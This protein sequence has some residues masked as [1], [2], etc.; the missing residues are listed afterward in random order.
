VVWAIVVAAGSG[1]RYGRPKQF[2]LLDGTP[3]VARSVTACRSV[4]TGVVVVLPQDRLDENY[5]ADVAVAGGATRSDSVRRG[6]AAVPD[7]ASV[8]VVHDAARPLAGPELFGAVVAALGR[9]DV[10]GAICG[11]AVA[12]TLKRV[13]EAGRVD[14]TVA[15]DNLVAVQTPQGFRA[16]L[17]RQAHADGGEATDDA[18]LVEALGAT[19][20]VV[21]GDPRNVK[22]TTPADLDYA[23]HVLGA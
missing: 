17:L 3:V 4:A 15:R 22:L 5:G 19:V 14:G 8:V 11:V 18:A 13:S 6:L 2:D 23:H 9:P 21:P 12:D 16:P 7:E 1:T 10:G 20:V